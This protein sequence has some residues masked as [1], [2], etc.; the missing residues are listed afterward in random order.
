MKPNDFSPHRRIELEYGRYINHLFSKYFSEGSTP[1]RI[2][3]VFAR[4]AETPAVTEDIAARLAKRM[5]T[6]VKVK[7]A[8]S[9]REA[10][11]E[12]SRGREIYEALQTEMQ[13]PVGVRVQQI[14]A[15]NAKLI[16]SIP[17]KV[18]EHVN[19]EIA[20]MQQQ[21]ER[22]ELIAEYLKRR[23]P[24]LTR[25]Q[26]RL[27]ARTETGK[28]ATA[29]TRARSEDLGINW[30]QWATSEDSRVRPAHRLMDKVLV[31]WDDPPSPEALKGIRSTLG[32][33]NAGDAP[34]CRCDTYPLVS[35]EVVSW[36][37]RVYSHGS[38]QRM[39]K[40]QFMEFS[41]MRRAA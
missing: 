36:P 2:L 6:Q 37:A 34:N 15:E 27:I 25:N 13:G 4:L 32:H 8:R 10:A 28:A 20:S 26:A 35:L 24:E 9:W 40:R 29:L 31:A 39:G 1:Q 30:Y 21:G 3:E 41:G 17:A 18:R 14:V 11:R 22:P 33:Y 19:V 7:N 23:I 38:I 12:A 16:G 5:V